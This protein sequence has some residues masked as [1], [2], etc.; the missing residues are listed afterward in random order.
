MQTTFGNYTLRLIESGDLDAYYE[1]IDNNRKRL[2]DFFAGTVA[3]TKTKEDTA[4][5]LADVLD[6]QS[7]N[8]YFSFVVANNATGK[9]VS[10]IQVKSIDWSI[11]KAELG[12]YI[13]AA[14]EGRGLVTK[15]VASIIDYCF[16][17]HGFN[18]LYIRT[19]EKNIGSRKV[20]E[21]N[22]F[23]VEGIIRME[24][25]TTAGQI[26]DFMYYGLLRESGGDTA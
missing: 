21:K 24:Y 2:E 23:I 4:R 11:P 13:D 19:H 25:K 3:L 16:N 5:H 26:I 20:A 10:S 22:G 15:A 14:C 12:Y 9:L 8:K 6:L 1:L 18:K 7:K 17:T